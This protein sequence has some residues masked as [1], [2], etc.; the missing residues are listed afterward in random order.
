MSEPIGP[1]EWV[2]CVDAGPDSW[3]RAVPLE[4]GGVYLV[5]SVCMAEDVHGVLGPCVTLA[6]I[7]DEAELDFARGVIWLSAYDVSRFRP[8]YRP[9]AS[10]IQSL[11]QPLPAEP[12]TEAA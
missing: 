11:L 10:L 4:V 2:E 6:N 12:V 5:A 3:G 7:L 8:I 9:K 1:G